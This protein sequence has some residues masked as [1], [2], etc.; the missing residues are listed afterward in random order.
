MNINGVHAARQPAGVDSVQRTGQAPRAQEVAQGHDVVEIST[1]A[2][3]AAQVQD[4]PAVR[5]D[6]VARVKS[7]IASGVY[8][9][10]EKLDLAID[11]LMEELYPDL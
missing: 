1:A 4:V 3:L 10:S 6:L 8:E 7:E 9:T 2:R 11:R 5:A